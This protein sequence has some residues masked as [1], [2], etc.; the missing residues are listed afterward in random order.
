MNAV[1]GIFEVVLRNSI[2]RHY[3]N[4]KGNEWL[5]NAVQ[6]G[7]Y[8]EAAPEC[9]NSYNN[10]QDTIQKL[11][12]DYTHENLIAKLP[13]GFWVYQYASIKIPAYFQYLIQNIDT[14]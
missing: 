12:R 13:F 9:I 14:I 11:G 1:I 10:V 7:R 5:A 3:T 8:L 6:P 4:K 2:H